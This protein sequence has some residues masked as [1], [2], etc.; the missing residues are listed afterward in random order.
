MAVV[1][2]AAAFKKTVS[3]FEQQADELEG[4]SGAILSA[5][6]KIQADRVQ[7]RLERARKTEKP[8]ARVERAR[9]R[10][11][12]ALYDLTTEFQ[13]S[14][15]KLAPAVE[16]GIDSL[17][18]MLRFGEVAVN[19]LQILIDKITFDRASEDRNRVELKDANEKLA[20]AML[21]LALQDRK[22]PDD[23]TKWLLGLDPF[24][25]APGDQAN[26]GP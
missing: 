7:N 11:E 18:A 23:H 16:I 13:Q 20:E 2:L 9:G 4:V 12:D 15:G 22:A 10:L 17:T 5:R 19:H 25:K 24:E 26:P 21:E 14:F 3:I 8:I 6:L 1:A